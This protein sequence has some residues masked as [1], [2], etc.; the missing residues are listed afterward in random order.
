M[1]R[2][3]TLS[4]LLL[5]FATGFYSCDK[6]C[7]INKKRPQD[8]K[9]IDWE[10]YND[11]YTIYWNSVHLCSENPFSQ[12]DSTDENWGTIKIAGWHAWSYDSFVLCDDSKYA[13][14]KLGHSAAFPFVAISFSRIPE[15]YSIFETCDMTKKMFITGDLKFD[16]SGRD[17]LGPCCTHAP[18]IYANEVYFE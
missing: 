8:L 3:L 13:D 5:F 14:P 4:T 12:H 7:Y 2:I 15:I 17:N 6:T 18:V 11:A 10:N 9:P 16:L 1:K